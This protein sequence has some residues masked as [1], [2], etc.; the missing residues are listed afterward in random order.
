MWLWGVIPHTT[1]V[2]EVANLALASEIVIFQGPLTASRHYRN[3]HC[4]LVGAIAGALCGT[5]K[6]GGHTS[7]SS[8]YA[9]FNN[10]RV[11]GI[12]HHRG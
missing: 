8:F 3:M 9:L 6:N 2:I 5:I 10:T 7:E 4:H 1:Q 11:R 12:T